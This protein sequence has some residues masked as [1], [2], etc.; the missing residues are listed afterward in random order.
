[1]PSGPVRIGLWTVVRG[2]LLPLLV[3]TGFA[4]LAYAVYNAVVAIVL[5]GIFAASIVAGVWRR[6]RGGHSVR[7]S[8]Y[9]ALGAVLK[10][11]MAGL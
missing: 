6:R 5:V 11:S 2:S 9:G 4:C 7:C 10:W 8:V 1:M 3:W